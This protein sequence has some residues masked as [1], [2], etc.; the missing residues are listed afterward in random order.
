ME[1]A[2][3]VPEGVLA[4]PGKAVEGMVFAKFLRE[5]IFL[6]WKASW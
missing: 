2:D 5:G 1:E 3:E 4:R 6:R